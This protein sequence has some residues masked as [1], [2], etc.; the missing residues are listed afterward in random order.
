ME[1][2]LYLITKSLHLLFVMAWVACVFYL[3]RFLINM[4]EVGDVP[5]INGRLLLM[6][7]RLYRFGH[8]MFGI[9]FVLGLY[10]WLRYNLGGFWIYGKLFFVSLM[11][12][13]FV[14]CGRMLKSDVAALPSTKVLRMMNELPILVVLIIIYLVLAKPF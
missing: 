5:F 3:P 14:L 7:K 4:K 8:I 10:L 2:T 6:G 13:Y 12:A 11:L 9:A 1:P